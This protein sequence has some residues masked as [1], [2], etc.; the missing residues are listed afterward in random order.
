[1]QTDIRTLLRRVLPGSSE[2]ANAICHAITQR[3]VLCLMPT[4]QNQLGFPRFAE[5]NHLRAVSLRPNA[6]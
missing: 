3:T 5:V 4:R 2:L 6:A 1:M